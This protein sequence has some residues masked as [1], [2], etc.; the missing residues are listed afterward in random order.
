M[1]LPDR[2]EQIGIVV[3]SALLVALPISLLDS[4]VD[5][6]I[7]FWLG[8]LVILGPGVIVGGLVITDRLPATYTQVWAFSLWSWLLAAIGLGVF[9][10]SPP[11]PA[12]ERPSALG[13]WIAAVVAGGFLAWLRPIAT[14]RRRFRG[15][16]DQGA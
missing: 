16:D 5:I 6:D 7:G 8:V 14:V 12:S 2:A 10:F 9:G 11:V 4:I 13:V 1:E 3:G 15:P